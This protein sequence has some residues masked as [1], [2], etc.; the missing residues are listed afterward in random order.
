MKYHWRQKNDSA[1]DSKNET[2]S[3]L[4]PVTT[5]KTVLTSRREIYKLAPQ[6]VISLLLFISVRVAFT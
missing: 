6:L 1:I 3:H 4:M 2:S 5:Y